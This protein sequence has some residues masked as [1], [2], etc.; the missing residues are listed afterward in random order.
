M[1]E[2][3]RRRVFEPF[4]STKGLAN[5][6]GLGLGSAF[7]FVTQSGGTITVRSEPGKGSTFD[8]YLPLK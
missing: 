2:E 7:G 4:F 8:V 1:D 6:E 3:T 5:A